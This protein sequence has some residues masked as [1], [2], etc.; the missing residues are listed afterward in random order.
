[1]IPALETPP[2]RCGYTEA[3]RVSTCAGTDEVDDQPDTIERQE[4]GVY[5]PKTHRTSHDD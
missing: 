3:V 2:P 1:M 4:A 5:R